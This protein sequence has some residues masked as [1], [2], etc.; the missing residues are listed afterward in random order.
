MVKVKNIKAYWILDS[1]GIPTIQCELTVENLGKSFTGLASVPSG[2]STGKYEALELRDQG[3]SFHGK[4]VLE[5]IKNILEKIK[6]V[7]LEAEF[8]N[9]KNLD[10]VILKLDN[11]SSKSE[12]GANAILAVSMATHRAFAL[13]ENLPLHAYLRKIYFSNLN[14]DIIF[15][16]L[17]CNVINGGAHA[18]SGLS[19]QEFM[20]VPKSGSLEKDVQILSEVYHSLKKSLKT[21]GEVVAVGDEGGFAPHIKSTEA[22]LELLHKLLLDSGYAE[23]CD[24]AL[25]VAASEFYQ[26]E[27]SQIDSATLGAIYNYQGRFLKADELIQEYIKLSQ[28]FPIISIED[29]LA[30]DDLLGWKTLTKNLGDKVMLVGDDLFVTNKWR[31]LSIGVQQSIANSILI[32]PNQIGSI[33]ETCEVINLA[34]QNNFKPVISHRSGETS[35]AF[36]SDL[37]IACQAPFFKAGAVARGERLAKYNRLLEINHSKVS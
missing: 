14:E 19:V 12:L 27:T 34:Y 31:L 29:G 2:A 37:V 26:T 33:S 13:V 11:S 5:A 22:V 9:A 1:R 4:G 35:D 21:S 6:P 8:E 24:L 32:K 15:P 17:M 36:I 3:N 23:V 16:R 10:N 30:E 25:D 7:V 28:K 18:D 20:I